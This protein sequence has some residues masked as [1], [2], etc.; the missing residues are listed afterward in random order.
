MGTTPGIRRKWTAESIRKI[1]I[2]FFKLPS[3]AY[4]NNHAKKRF[5]TNWIWAIF[6]VGCFVKMR[7]CLEETFKKYESSIGL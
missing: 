2:S 6:L 7:W 5:H 4:I 1:G 3:R